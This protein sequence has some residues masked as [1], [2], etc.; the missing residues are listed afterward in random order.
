[1]KRF[2][3]LGAGVQSSTL[4]LMIEAGEVPPVDYAIFADTGDEPQEVY[5]WL[6]WIT[7]KLSYPVKVVSGGRLSDVST[8]LR[9]SGRSGNTYLRSA[10]PA[11]IVGANG[12]LGMGQRQCTRNHK[13]DP[14]NK[15]V[16]TLAEVP[17]G[18]KT[19]VA[20]V[21][22]GI[23]VDEYLRAKPSQKPWITHEWPLLELGMSRQ[24]CFAWMAAH[25]YPAPPRSACRFCPYKSDSEWLRLKTEHPQEFAKA[26][27]YEG[28]LQR[29]YSESTALTGVPFLHASRKPLTDVAFSDNR[30]NQIDAFN[31]ECEGMCGV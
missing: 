5:D 25:G 20:T 12:K 21:L 14:I 17:R 27:E 11:F 22:I 24:D 3:S 19:P 29:A 18:C 4:A 28:R 2:L 16:R 30:E 23:S 31:N 1:M 7:G 10:I 6:A 13:I 26:V 8:T 15:L 9:V